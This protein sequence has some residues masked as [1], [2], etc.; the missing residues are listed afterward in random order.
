MMNEKLEKLFEQY[1]LSPKERYEFMQIYSLLPPLKKVRA[2]ERFEI[3]MMEL[4][5]LKKELLYEQETLFGHT[6][7]SI[8]E[9]IYQLKKQSLSQ[10]VSSEV[11]DLKKHL[12][13][14]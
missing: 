12:L 10:S 7:E 1:S 13:F 5:T 9:K 3:I 4:E 11:Q 8:E 2:L 6:L 14:Y